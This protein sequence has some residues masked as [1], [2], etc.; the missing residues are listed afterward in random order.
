MNMTVKLCL[1]KYIKSWKRNIEFSKQAQGNFDK[2][3]KQWI[4]KAFVESGN[5]NITKFSV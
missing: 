5:S 4:R 2:Y 1:P 3:I